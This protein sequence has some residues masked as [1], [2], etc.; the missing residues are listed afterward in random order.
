MAFEREW[1]ERLRVR[2]DVAAEYA[3]DDGR[4]ALAATLRDALLALPQPEE[5]EEMHAEVQ[6]LMRIQEEAADILRAVEE[7]YQGKDARQRI[8]E[9][10][11][12][13]RVL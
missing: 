10:I 12:L 3:L 13:W 5:A 8:G 1:I 7:G 9:R 2:L 6:R 4:K 11:A